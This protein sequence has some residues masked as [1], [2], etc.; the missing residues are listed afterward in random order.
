MTVALGNTAL[1][2]ALVGRDGHSAFR[3]YILEYIRLGVMNDVA[4]GV[5]LLGE[6]TSV[7][8]AMIDLRYG[9]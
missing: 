8:W 5:A 3:A 4:G 7:Y 1:L 2:G 9:V 6:G